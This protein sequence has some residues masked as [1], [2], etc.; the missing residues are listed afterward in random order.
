MKTVRLIIRPAMVDNK[1]IAFLDRLWTNPDVMRFVGFP[2]GLRTRRAAFPSYTPP[3]LTL[4]I[5]IRCVLHL[6]N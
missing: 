1:D 3:I 4:C 2:S 6:D 5:V